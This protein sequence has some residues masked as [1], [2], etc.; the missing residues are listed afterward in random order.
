MHRIGGPLEVTQIPS[1]GIPQGVSPADKH[2]AIK[3]AS[4]F[5]NDD[6]KV[7]SFFSVERKINICS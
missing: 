2:M 4:H 1:Q 3:T 7:F 5:S 6:Y